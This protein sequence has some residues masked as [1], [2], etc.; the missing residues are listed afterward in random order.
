MAL[1]I[2]NISGAELDVD[3]LG[4]SLATGATMDLSIEADPYVVANSALSGGDINALITSGSIVVK[5][6][7]DNVTNLSMAEALIA[8]RTHNDPPYQLMR[9]TGSVAQSANGIKT[10]ND[11]VIIGPTGDLVFEE[12]GAGTNVVGFTAPAALAADTI[13]TLPN[14][15][16]TISGQVLSSNG[17]GLLSWQ[18]LPVA[19]DMASVTVGSTTT[20]AI[21]AT[22]TNI[23]WNT[24]HVENDTATIEHDNIN[25][26]RILIKE[27]GLYF[28]NFS[29]SFNSDPGEE[30][31][32]IRVFANNTTVVPGSLRVA[33]E[34]DEI[35][36]LSNA[37]T[38]ELT[39]GDFI[40][41]QNQASGTGNTLDSSC[42][43]SVTRASGLMGAQGPV[44]PPGG[45]PA[46]VDSNVQYNNGGVFGGNNAF[47][48][49]DA[50][51]QVDILGNSLDTQLTIGG[52]AQVLSGATNATLYVEVDSGGA[53][54]EA[55]RFFFNRGPAISGWISYDYDGTAPNIRIVDEDD[56]P[57]YITFETINA[58]TVAAPQ[59]SNRF[60][61]RGPVAGATTGFSWQV[62]G[63]EVAIMDTNFIDITT[64]TGEYRVNGTPLA[65]DNL[66]DVDT[67]TT[68]PVAG[69]HLEFDG[70]DWTPAV[71]LR[72]T[73]CIF[74]EENQAVT[75][76]A[77]NYEFSYGNGAVNTADTDPSG[78]PLG[79]NCTLIGIG[80]SAHSTSG[81]ATV[82]IS[83][84]NNGSVVATGGLASGATTNA[85]VQDFTTI[86][87][88]TVNFVPGDTVQFRTATETST[89]R[90]VRVVAWFERTS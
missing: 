72:P 78:I 65:L 13:W 69:D 49:N 61:T 71:V 35:N 26:S 6:P 30:T 32:S 63:S 75:V 82:S 59:F 17:A 52:D 42:S 68:A 66:S 19:G 90:D 23:P 22:F 14:A 56:D 4:F 10:F 7:N 81:L 45:N 48:F 67:T 51:L 57:T 53:G 9:L 38:A 8:C 16:A 12:T 85:K 76:G 11:R 64:A 50:A 73:F 70:V 58:G 60:G 62:N 77:N 41:L 86:T 3:D 25:T 37:F 5:D 54:D 39:A 84:I 21:P 29:I 2:E 1:I 28:I 89:L 83:V 24:T 36:D 27:T 47:N 43:F 33:S 44:G 34:D 55:A 87:P 79:V 20:P 74:A 40:T 80:V 88:D 18:T 46:G 15:D 31:I